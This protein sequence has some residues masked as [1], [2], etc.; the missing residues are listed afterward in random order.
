MP[1]EYL[2]ELSSQKL[3]LRVHEPAAI[4]KLRVLR[5]AHLVVVRMPEDGSEEGADAE[6]L[7]I[8]PEGRAELR[9]AGGR[10]APLL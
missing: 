3:P 6:V 10:R 9:R 8:T 5:A 7:A 2:S 1:L 4:D